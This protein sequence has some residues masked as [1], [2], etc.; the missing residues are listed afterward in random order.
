MVTT[1]EQNQTYKGIYL[2]SNNFYI[3]QLSTTQGNSYWTNALAIILIK[4]IGTDF[5]IQMR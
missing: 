1:R 2:D 3:E 4:N 5:L